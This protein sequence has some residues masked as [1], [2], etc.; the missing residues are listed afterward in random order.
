[1]TGR[2]T[3]GGP[4]SNA[5]RRGE[6]VHSTRI[7]SCYEMRYVNTSVTESCK[8]RYV[9]TKS[10][11]TSFRCRL[12]RLADIKR[13]A[14]V[15]ARSR[16]EQYNKCI[17]IMRGSLDRMLRT[18]CSVGY[19]VFRAAPG[20]TGTSTIEKRDC[21]CRVAALHDIG[22]FMLN[23]SVISLPWPAALTCTAQ[24]GQRG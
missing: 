2:R 14:T 15:R 23:R 4:L 11:R 20:P 13:H 24:H 18:W 19:P 6:S 10:I 8:M 7:T 21:D 5:G 3:A 22:Q 9:N 1:M 16:Y 12:S 17:G